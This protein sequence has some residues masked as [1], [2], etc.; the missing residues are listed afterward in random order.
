M[1]YG[2]NGTI[3]EEWEIVETKGSK[4]ISKTSALGSG[5]TD[6]EGN[7]EFFDAWDKSSQKNDGTSDLLQKSKRV[8]ASPVPLV[9]TKPSGNVG[10]IGGSSG[11]EAVK[12][13]SR[14]KAIS[15]DQFFG[16]TGEMDVS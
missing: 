16:R 2:G 5:F 7:E 6:D 10:I 12:K 9:V 15:S 14:A 3:S 1:S 8:A 4:N 13:F 11:D